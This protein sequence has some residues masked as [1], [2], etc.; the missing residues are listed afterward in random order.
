[1]I[2]RLCALLKI[3]IPERNRGLLWASGTVV[4][5]D[6]ADG[7][8]TG[9]IFQKTDGGDGT[10]LYI[11][12]GS[13]TACDFNAVGDLSTVDYSAGGATAITISG[14]YTVE[15][16]S[17]TKDSVHGIRVGAFA[18]SGSTA[19]AMVLDGTTSTAV[20]VHGGVSAD[21]GSGSN[22]RPL[23]SR[24]IV[25]TAGN[26]EAETY[27]MQGQLVVKSSN[28]G[29]WHGGVMGTVECQTALSVY[30]P[31]AGVGALVGRIGGSTITVQ[32]SCYLA[33]VIAL[34]SAVGVS[35]SGVYAG[36]Y[37][38][39][40]S[41]ASNFSHGAYIEDSDIGVCVAGSTTGILLSGTMTRGIHI[42]PTLTIDASM[43]PIQITYNYDGSTNTG[44]D[45]DNYGLR[46][47][48]TQTG[49]ND[50][51]DIGDRGFILGI[52]SD[53]HVDG[54]VDDAY[55]LYGKVYIDG[56]SVANQ[57]YGLNLVLARGANTIAMDASGMYAGLG[58]AMSGTGDVTRS[59]A[60]AVVCGIYVNW[61]ERHAMTVPTYGMM[62]NVREAGRMDYGFAVHGGYVTSCF[63]AGGSTS[64]TNVLEVA[65]AHTNLLK[66][67]AEN[68][69]PVVTSGGAVGVHGTKT[70]AIKILI[71]TTAYYLLASTIPTYSG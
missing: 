28:L 26:V 10:S 71:D 54:Y 48:I 15:G 21:P 46:C 60:T 57:I 59:G 34:A 51:A 63:Y 32:S 25:N 27:G 31:L 41:G 49:S 13:V 52:R 18:A 16:I 12:E 65:T 33:G 37:V 4:P 17:I 5:S 38:A 14:A 44:V 42:T 36:L 62:L 19:S 39:K 8:Q 7:Y 35:N 2:D 40:T 47:A 66:L 23:R 55:A 70:V 20:E 1:M 68:T 22:L 29:H 45:L 50:D 64:H 11:N 43:T 9:C 56:T 61:D 30:N 67:P 6:N 24:L 69:A 3:G 53:I 58:I